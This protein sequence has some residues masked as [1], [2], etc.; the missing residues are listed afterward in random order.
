[1][2]WNLP[3]GISC[4]IGGSVCPAEPDED[5]T[6]LYHERVERER[7]VN[8][9]SRGSSAA[10]DETAAL[11]GL[12]LSVKIAETSRSGLKRAAELVNRTNQFN[13]C[14]SRTTV[15]E[16]EAGIGESHHVIT[17]EAADKF[18]NIWAW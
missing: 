5:R 13:L 2:Q 3:P 7:F 8:E 10:E 18:G 14:G 16:L 11:K 1:M 12:Q 15:R 4:L 17:V 9:A 6:K